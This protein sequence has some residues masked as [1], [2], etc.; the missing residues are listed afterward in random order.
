LARKPQSAKNR[1]QDGTDSALRAFARAKFERH[2]GWSLRL[3][4]EQ[5]LPK[6]SP[7]VV[8]NLVRAAVRLSGKE[9][10]VKSGSKRRDCR[11]FDLDLP[12][13]QRLGRAVSEYNSSLPVFGL[14]EFLTLNSFMSGTR[15]KADDLGLDW[16]EAS[17]ILRRIVKE[18]GSGKGA[19]AEQARDT[20]RSEV[21]GKEHAGQPMGLADLPPRQGDFSRYID[22]ANLTQ[23]QRECVSFEWEYGLNN[24]QIARRLGLNR[25]TVQEHLSRARSKMERAKAK[26]RAARTRARTYPGALD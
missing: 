12:S 19:T 20:E 4:R 6:G 13:R 21:Q 3:L 14:H 10:L 24:T 17:R 7:R 22:N 9:V 25:S 11:F 1:L 26:E 2:V 8:S 16:P 18:F 23:R 15:S 5:L